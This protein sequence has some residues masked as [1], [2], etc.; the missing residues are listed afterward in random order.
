[1]P[2]NCT[3]TDVPQ[4]KGGL[5]NPYDGHI[6]PYSLTQALAAGARRH[7]ALVRPHSEVTGLH[8]LEDGRWRVTLPQGT[9]T[10]SRLVNAAGETTS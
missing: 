9:I 6:D 4:I 7:G 2:I 3:F 10:A 5:L 8:L 1:M